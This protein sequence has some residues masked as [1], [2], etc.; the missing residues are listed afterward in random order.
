MRRELIEKNPLDIPEAGKRVN[1][2]E[3]YLPNDDELHAILE[4]V[5]KGYRVVTSLMLFHGLRIGEAL[6][7]EQR[8]VRF[9]YLPAPWMPR[10][11]VTVEQNVQRLRDEEGRISSYVQPPKS[12]AGYR[13]VPVMAQHVPLFLEHF[14]RHLPSVN[15]PGLVRGH[16]VTQEEH[17]GYQ[18]LRPGD[19]SAGG[20]PVLRGAR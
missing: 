15:R 18:P 3:K 4:T 17:H 9:E 6:A 10:I 16:D 20:A 11:T 7:L 19:P 12:E 5:P 13:D 2:K 8:H 14:A 1:T